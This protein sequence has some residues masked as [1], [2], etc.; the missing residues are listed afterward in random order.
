MGDRPSHNLDGLDLDLARRIDAV[1]R[2]FEADWRAGQRPRVADYLVDVPEPGQSAL[3]AELIALEQE[4]CAAPGRPDPEDRP[5]MAAG[6][7]EP[8]TVRGEAAG[9]PGSEATVDFSRS[10]HERTTAVPGP[11]GSASPRAPEPCRV[12]YFGDYEILKEIARGGMGVVFLARQMSLNRP[13]ALKMILAGQLANETDI[14]RFYLEAEAAANLDH[15]GI[16]PIYEVGQH[17]G[18]H[19]FSMGFVEGES[20]AQ[21]VANGPL[22]PREAAALLLKVSE[23]IEYANRFGVVHRDLKPANILIDHHGNPRITDFGLAKKVEGDSGLTGSGQIMGTPSYMPPEQASRGRGAVGPAADV[24]AIGATLY[25]LVTG[26]PPFQA[27]TPM[28]TILMV[29]GEEP[30]PPRRLNAS[31]PLDLETIILK[32]LEKDPARRY[33]SAAAL[34]ED[35]RHYLAG[36]TLVARPVGQAERAWRWCR[37]NPVVAGLAAGIALSLVLGTAIAT[38]FA[39]RATRGEQLALQNA[40]AAQANAQRATEETQRANQEAQ[41]AHEEKLLSDRHLYVAQMSLA[42]QAWRDSQIDAALEHLQAAEP[43]RTEDADLRGFEWSYL[44]RLC[45]SDLRTLRGHSDPVRAVAFSRDGG[46]LASASADRTVK[47]WESATGRNIRTLEQGSAAGGVAFSPDGRT[48]AS[49]NQDGTVKL[50][51]AA[52]GTDIRTLRGHPGGVMSVAFSPDGHLLASAGSDHV[53]RL[54]DTASG[55]DIRALR[56]HADRVSSVAFSP[57]GR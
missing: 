48:L 5:G 22:P 47:L 44:Q 28:D 36:E 13:V 33:A 40:M 21:K 50:W 55:T 24:Y 46:T 57:D 27:A 49:A 23:A 37:R 42:E 51:N 30:V 7:P 18:Q 14:L 32:C 26:R 8:S 11:A 35:L 45:Q 31:V 38:H 39:V 54:W 3:R 15:P 1:C 41:R 9:P 34:S 56:G 12:R 20:L 53:V 19:Y 2:Q 17:E 16:V 4:L 10:P 52:S 29:L 6:A 25:C 43:R